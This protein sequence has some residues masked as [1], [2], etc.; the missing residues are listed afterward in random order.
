VREGNLGQ[1]R[2][3]YK[4]KRKIELRFQG[5]WREFYEKYLPQVKKVG[6]QE[7]QALCPFHEDSKPS[8]NFNDG[9][10]AYFC[11][12]CGK[13]GGGFHFYARTHGLDVRR[14]FARVLR[15]I[16]QD[17]GIPWEEQE[18]RL[19][20]TY[21]YVD[22]EGK[23]LFQV[24]RYEPKAFKQRR[25]D[26]KGGWKWD[27]K[28]VETVPYRLPEVL[29]AVEV[30]IVEGEKDVESLFALGFVATT[31]PMGARKWRDSFNQYLQGKDI[32]LIPDNDREGRE[33][34][35]QVAISLNGMAKSLKWLELPNLPSKGDVS[36][37]IASYGEDKEGAAERLA[38][39][40][41][42]AEPYTPPK[43][44]TLE[45]IIITAT[46]F[47][48]LALPKRT[49]YLYPW[50]KEDS[51]SLVS[52]WRG[53]GKTWFSWGIADAV[54]KGT[55]FGP[56]TCEKPVPVLIL[57]GEMPATDLQERVQA[58]GLNSDRSCLLYIYSDALA[59]QS[60]LPRANLGNESWREKM[61]S[62]LLGR[63]VKLLILDNIASLAGGLDE[64]KKLDWDPINAWLLELRFAG[65]ATMLLHHT[66]KLG[67]QRG[68][69]AREDNIDISLIL[70]SPFDYTPDDGCRFICSFNKARVGMSGLSLITDAEF[71]LAQ[72]PSGAYVWT[73]ASVK[74]E[75]RR[76]ILE[77]K[78][79]G[80]DQKAISE[81]LG[82]SKG[83]VSKTLKQATRDGLLNKDGRL[84][85][86]GY[87]LLYGFP[88]DAEN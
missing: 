5:N 53:V 58:L 9:T 36:D 80:V 54:S 24:C 52:G 55:S 7:Y 85:Q 66:G 78:E 72:E 28:G 41:Q 30:L 4:M 6:G 11:H 71:K 10:G 84:S 42:N 39:M 37:F 44:K 1:L 86:K 77:L 47:H 18:R 67:L 57:D 50:L 15:G 12:G 45:D 2:A 21:H 63:H 48:A 59:N 20:K 81:T 68:T 3:I 32:V 83:Y 40:L 17:F 56:W 22:A 76:A 62:I 23:L 88:N 26:G 13:K 49:H 8:F 31:S 27:L 60:G 25:P 74:K 75:A 79:K 33:H 16:A 51:I 61:K 19:V 35:T 34:M 69:S 70:K 46:D 82:L 87:N 65:I 73:W 43:K 29:K 14:D 38:I 64:N